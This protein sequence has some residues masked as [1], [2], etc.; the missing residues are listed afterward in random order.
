MN[1]PNLTDILRDIAST[2]AIL[3]CQTCYCPIV[4]GEVQVWRGEQLCPAC[5]LDA[6][7]PVAIEA[8][9]VYQLRPE[10]L[11]V[12]IR[13]SEV[14]TNCAAALRASVDVRQRMEEER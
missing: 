10:R 13:A 5:A 2:P 9:S 6:V 4:P 7:A 1:E 14:L 11:A 3:E 8:L 12:L